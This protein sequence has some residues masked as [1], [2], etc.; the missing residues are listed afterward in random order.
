M[1][2]KT[3]MLVRR[4]VSAAGALALLAT[5]SGCGVAGAL[6]RVTPEFHEAQV[7]GFGLIGQHYDAAV[8]KI[9]SAGFKCWRGQE[10]EPRVSYKVG[11]PTLTRTCDKPSF[12]FFCP[13]RRY[14][15]FE[16]TPDEKKVVYVTTPSRFEEQSCF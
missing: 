3:P 2:N 15:E 11:V 7:A 6:T 10:H 9:E 13:Q 8:Q 4:L 14:V 16:Y 5:L 1:R 12:E